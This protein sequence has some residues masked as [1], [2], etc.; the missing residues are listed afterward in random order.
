M[1]FVRWGTCSG[2]LV[3]EYLLTML[4]L[5]GFGFLKFL[6]FVSSL[7]CWPGV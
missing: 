3:Y 6:G 7:S 1:G 2:L 4:S 5:G